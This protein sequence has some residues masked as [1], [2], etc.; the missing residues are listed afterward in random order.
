[1]ISI[2]IIIGA[3]KTAVS[4]IK[5]KW[6]AWRDYVILILLGLVLVTG[7][8][9]YNMY[10]QNGVLDAK[11][12]NEINNRMQYQA[13]VNNKEN[14]NRVLRLNISDLSH[15]NDSLIQSLNETRKSLKIKDNALKQ[16]LSVSTVIRDTITI[17]LP[18]SLK[19]SV[20]FTAK[21]EHNPLTTFTIGRVDGKAFCIPEIY[22]RQDLFIHSRKEYRNKKN[23]FQRLFTLDWK[24]DKI[25]RYN[26]INSNLAIQVL[27]TR[28]IE[29]ETE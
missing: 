17:V 13:M 29:V 28:I 9:S 21:L 15:S 14:D 22:N 11:L 1:M 8:F 24:K 3:I 7:Y 19:Q 26:I 5:S 6:L 10:K 20:D 4:L 2:S 12:G 23:F 25:N 16:A 18:D 27:N